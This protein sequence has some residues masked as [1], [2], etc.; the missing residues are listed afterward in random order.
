MGK[1]DAARQ[2]IEER[3]TVFRDRTYGDRKHHIR[4]QPNGLLLNVIVKY[5]YDRQTLETVGDVVTA[6]FQRRLRD[7]DYVLYVRS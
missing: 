2:A 3:D 5:R 4:R 1:L 6:F 7:G